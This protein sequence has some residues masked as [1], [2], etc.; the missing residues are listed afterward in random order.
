MNI[1]LSL[2]ALRCRAKIAWFDAKAAVTRQYYPRAAY[3]AGYSPDTEYLPIIGADHVVTDHVLRRTAHEQ[4]LLHP[5]VHL[6]IFNERGEILV[7]KRGGSKDNSAGKLAQ[8]VGGHLSAL[9]CPVGEPVHLLTSFQAVKIES[10]QELGISLSQISFIAEFRH[11]SAGGKNQ[12][13]ATLFLGWTNDQIKANRT[14]LSWAEWF[15]PF[16]VRALSISSPGLFS[17][18]FLTDLAK[19]ESAGFFN[20]R[21][22]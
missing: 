22:K 9:N 4:G 16:Q 5:T 11:V 17:P 18:S 1:N 2:V 13:F 15:D 21:P 19:L 8:S 14:E 20:P 10:S 7:Q 6:I 12:E 3:Q